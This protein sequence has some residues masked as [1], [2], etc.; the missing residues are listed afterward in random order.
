MIT[1]DEEWTQQLQGE[2]PIPAQNPNYTLPLILS[3]QDIRDLLDNPTR[4]GLAH[5]L[6]YA[7]GI[8]ATELLELPSTNIDTHL[9]IANRLVLIDPQTATALAALAQDSGPLLF[10]W[11]QKKLHDSLQTSR[12]ARL[13]QASDRTLTPQALRHAFATHRLE[14]GMDPVALHTLLGN[15][16]FQTTE[17]Y[18]LTAVALQKTEYARCHPLMQKPEKGPP[19]GTPS[20]EEIQT[21]IAAAYKLRDKIIIRLFYAT[22]LRLA[23]LLNLRC[24]DIDLQEHRV[25]VRHG[26]G[27]K[28]RYTLIDPETVRQLQAYKP[29]WNPGE[30]VF[31]LRSGTAVEAMVRKLAQETGIAAPYEAK[32]QTI[33][34]HS[35]RH[36]Y[37]THCYLNGMELTS[38]KRL[39]GH[40]KLETTREY[41]D[42]PF[43]H[44]AK[45]YAQTHD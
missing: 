12:A 24:V 27:D 26:K 31:N 6:L 25:F 40:E 18:Q 7:S 22:G 17:M 44:T 2:L 35:L 20:Y 37:A 13:Y 43:S 14:N 5:R 33:S 4:E 41:L 39:L 10:P 36:S 15:Q 8:T 23:E 29:Q 45:V 21:L 34:P 3:R 42:I 19:P 28:D 16:L 11:T 9:T 38:L 1:A 32:G 30:S